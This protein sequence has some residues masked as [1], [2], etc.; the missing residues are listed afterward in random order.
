[1][2]VQ[3][4]GRDAAHLPCAKGCGMCGLPPEEQPR[5]A[6]A[7]PEP[8]RAGGGPDAGFTMRFSSVHYCIL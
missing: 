5:V 6:K 8:A 4:R 1:M 3:P 2:P 7:L